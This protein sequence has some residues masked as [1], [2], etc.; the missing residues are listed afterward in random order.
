MNLNPIPQCTSY[1]T[2]ESYACVFPP[3][4]PQG[5][6]NSPV[7]QRGS[8][9]KSTVLRLIR[10]QPNAILAR[11]WQSALVTDQVSTRYCPDPCNRE[12]FK[13][14]HSDNVVL[15]QPLLGRGAVPRVSIQ[16]IL[17]AHMGSLRIG[18]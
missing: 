6:K 12:T 16:Y 8:G 5:Q 2:L 7:Q 4:P 17:S 13:A 15:A 3:S 1:Y 10:D 14:F 11:L 18:A 9:R